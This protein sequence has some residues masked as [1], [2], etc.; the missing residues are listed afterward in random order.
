MV[1]GR[2]YY[3]KRVRRIAPDPQGRPRLERMFTES[4]YT[5]V[6]KNGESPVHTRDRNGIEGTWA[7]VAPERTIILSSETWFDV[8]EEDR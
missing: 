3:S 2:H 6:R 5:D 4:V 1:K 7:I 8:V